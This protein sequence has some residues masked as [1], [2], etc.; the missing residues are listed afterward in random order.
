MFRK[1]ISF[2]KNILNRL[3]IR[4]KMLIAL[5]GCMIIPMAL[6]GLF[7]A[8]RVTKLSAQNQYEAQIS[9]LTKSAKELENLHT[10]VEQEA[11]SLAGESSIQ[12]IAEGDASVMDYRTASERM[13]AKNLRQSRNTSRRRP[14][15][16]PRGLIRH[17]SSHSCQCTA[18]PLSHSS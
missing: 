11:K 10:M 7:T 18:A 16:R 12:A 14:E 17:Q 8:V 1:S 9:Q 5:I 2:M 3:S 15:S 13:S 6:L 4:Q